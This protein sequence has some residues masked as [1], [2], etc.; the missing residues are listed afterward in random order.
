MLGDSLLVEMLLVIVVIVVTL[1]LFAMMRL[2]SLLLRLI[3]H[4]SELM[5]T[6]C[7]HRIQKRPELE[8]DVTIKPEELV[9]DNLYMTHDGKYSYK[10]YNENRLKQRQAVKP[11]D[12][13]DEFEREA[14]EQERRV[15]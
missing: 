3:N 6:D 4:Y 5:L 10:V 2:G 7:I 1:S 8:V 13:I 14:I 11:E 12:T 15:K 9:K